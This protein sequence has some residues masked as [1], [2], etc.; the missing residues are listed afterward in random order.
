MGAL[1]TDPNAIQSPPISR[2]C[3]GFRAW[4]VNDAGAVLIRSVTMSRSKRTR[5]V[6]GSTRAPAAASR[7]RASS[8]R[9]SM[10][11]SSRTWSEASWIDSSSSAETTSVGL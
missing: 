3:S 2:W 10:P 5:S 9:K 8:S 11:I 7:S 6:P 1:A 4:S